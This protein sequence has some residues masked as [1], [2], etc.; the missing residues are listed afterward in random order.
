ME[1]DDLAQSSL[2]TFSSTCFQC[3]VR[4]RW[5]NHTTC[6]VQVTVLSLV[7][8]TRY[9]T[10]PL[11]T[12]IAPISTALS[13]R[14]RVSNPSYAEQRNMSTNGGILVGFPLPSRFT[15]SKLV[16]RSS[17]RRPVPIESIR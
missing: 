5:W 16:W 1:E 11:E 4:L 7:Q 8:P 13:I 10:K 3:T 15:P 14:H 12:P 6:T 17:G 2:C 9:C